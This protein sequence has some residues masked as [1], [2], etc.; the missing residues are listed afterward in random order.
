MHTF[1]RSQYDA[2]PRLLFSIS[3]QQTLPCRRLKHIVH[4]FARQRRAFEVL[5]GLDPPSDFFAFI[6]VDEFLAT[7]AHLF[8]CNGVVAEIFF[9][10]DENDGDAGAAFEDFGMPNKVDGVSF[11]ILAACLVVTLPF[12]CDVVE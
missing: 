9:Q 8:L 7:F 11:Q 4:A 6:G 1:S 10:A 3:A 12:R 2:T 5:L